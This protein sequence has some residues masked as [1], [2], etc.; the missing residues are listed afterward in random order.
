MARGGTD[1]RRHLFSSFIAH[2]CGIRGQRLDGYERK[3]GK[4]ADLKPCCV[5]S[6]WLFAFWPEYGRPGRV[7]YVI[8]W[9]PIRSCPATRRAICRRQG[10]SPEPAT[11][12]SGEAARPEGYGILQPRSRSACWHQPLRSCP[13]YG[14]E[15]GIDPDTQVI[16]ECLSYVFGEGSFIGK[17]LY[18]VDA[19]DR[20]WAGFPKNRILS[21]ICS[22]AVMPGGL[23]S[24]VQLF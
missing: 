5:Q 12:R 19:F 24:D 7:R 20:P 21:P 14:G 23:L 2:G 8:R 15:P 1:A 6:G 17:G 18:D 4:L 3:R 10:P 16:S 13:L 22:K 9:T 11:L